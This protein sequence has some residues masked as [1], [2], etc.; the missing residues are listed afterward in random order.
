MQELS[1]QA[2]KSK[3][4]IK[5]LLLN[6]IRVKSQLGGL[7]I[8]KLFIPLTYQGSAQTFIYRLVVSSQMRAPR[9]LESTQAKPRLPV[10]PQLPPAP[11]AEIAPTRAEMPKGPGFTA[12]P[13]PDIVAPDRTETSAGTPPEF[14]KTDT[15][16]ALMNSLARAE[17]RSEAPSHDRDKFKFS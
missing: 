6:D 12:P 11:A 1:Q 5:E 16:G 10:P 15:S 8:E 14:V 17:A 2:E 7:D 13:L 4:P 3:R 9:W